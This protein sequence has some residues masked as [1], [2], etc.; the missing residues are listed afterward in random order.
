[1]W[2]PNNLMYL[3]HTKPKQ[4]SLT[5]WNSTCE[6]FSVNNCHISEAVI[7]SVLR[8]M[9]W[10]RTHS[11][12]LWIHFNEQTVFASPSIVEEEITTGRGGKLSA[13]RISN[14]L[15]SFH[16]CHVMAC[17]RVSHVVVRPGP[18]TPWSQPYTCPF[19]QLCCL[20]TLNKIRPCPSSE[21]F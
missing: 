5:V 4:V 20:I 15:P 19:D 12:F 18:L 6:G 1:M 7:I 10:E 2:F 14:C 11:M 3:R 21:L 17:G 8:N 13:R 16:F 9:Q